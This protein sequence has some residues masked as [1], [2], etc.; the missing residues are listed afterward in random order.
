MIHY[1][2]YPIKGFVKNTSRLYC[3]CLSSNSKGHMEMGPQLVK[4]SSDRL[5]ELPIKPATPGLQGKWF[6]HYTIVTLNYIGPSQDK[7]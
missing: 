6:I 2:L 3:V 5:V 1:Q 7:F 4:V